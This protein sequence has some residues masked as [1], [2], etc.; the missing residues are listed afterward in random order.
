MNINVGGS[1][2]D[3]DDDLEEAYS[4]F[5]ETPIIN[6]YVEGFDDKRFWGKV[7]LENGITKFNIDAVGVEAKA[8]GKGTI[9]NLLKEKKIK[10][11]KYYLVCIDS[12]Y[13]NYY[14]LNQKV[15]NSEFCF[16][17]YAYSI[18]NL[19][20]HPKGL[21]ELCCNIAGNYGTEG[22]LC[23]ETLIS[24][25]S[26]QYYPSFVKLLESGSREAIKKLILNAKHT[27]VTQAPEVD[28]SSVDCNKF[29]Q[30]GITPD[31]LFLFYRGHNFEAQMKRLANR[32]II[33]LNK[34]VIEKISISQPA[35]KKKILIEEC[36]KNVLHLET[37][38]TLRNIPDSICFPKI[39]SDIEAY[40]LKYA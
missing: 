6:I 20:Y 2:F 31:N 37:A 32:V 1:D 19:Y 9:L 8:N 18:E 21:L 17:T 15:L 22:N 14:E 33:S 12:D 36:R 16:Q 27:G 4:V 38:V 10:L 5:G 7:F 30:I 28:I 23:F 25:W 39:V 13:D 40:K 35:E 24:E 11:G 29:N 3:E 34:P 26:N